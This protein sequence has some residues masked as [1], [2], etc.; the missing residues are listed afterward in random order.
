[1]QQLTTQQKQQL[2]CLL[3]KRLQQLVTAACNNHP[4]LE[5]LATFKQQQQQAGWIALGTP[6]QQ[7]ARSEAYHAA[8]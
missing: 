7:A 2:L 3:H 4:D 5:Q 8:K 6:L 1:M